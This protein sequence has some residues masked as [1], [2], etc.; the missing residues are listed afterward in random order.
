MRGLP[1]LL[2]GIIED[3][4]NQRTVDIRFIEVSYRKREELAELIEELR[5]EAEKQSSVPL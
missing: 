4:S 3:V 5:E 1:F 2:V